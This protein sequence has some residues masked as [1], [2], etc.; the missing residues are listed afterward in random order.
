MSDDPVLDEMRAILLM[1]E[2]YSCPTLFR[3]ALWRR[4]RSLLNRVTST[5]APSPTER[6]L[7]RKLAQLPPEGG[8]ELVQRDAA[9]IEKIVRKHWGDETPRVLAAALE[10]AK[11]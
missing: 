3:D 1:A 6:S 10:L 11:D 4:Q 7:S 5:D 8:P 9:A 2:Q